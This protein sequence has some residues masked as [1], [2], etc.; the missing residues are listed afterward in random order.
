MPRVSEQFR[1]PASF[2]LGL[3]GK[4]LKN[5]ARFF[6]RYTNAQRALLTLPPD[7]KSGDW[8]YNTDDDA[9]NF[10]SADK[11]TWRDAMGAITGTVAV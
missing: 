4:V 7:A 2:P 10:V 11:T 9:P 5:Q 1:L 6:G 8:I 3:A